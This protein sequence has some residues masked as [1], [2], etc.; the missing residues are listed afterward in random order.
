MSY[1][2]LFY[3]HFSV[4]TTN[5]PKSLATRE[6]LEASQYCHVDLKI[7]NHKVNS[8][9][10]DMPTT[11]AELRDGAQNRAQ[12]LRSIE[13]ADYYVGM[14]GGV[15]KDQHSDIY[16]LTGVV[17]IESFAGEGHFGYSCHLEVPRSVVDGLFDGRNRDMEEVM[18][19][20]SGIENIGDHQ[21]SFHA[22]TD[23]VLSRK[24]QFVLATQ[25]AIAPF[26]NEFYK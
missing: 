8:D 5:T 18:Q 19:E 15:Y 20:I 12:T 2:M 24:T 4:G 14:E 16:W 9:V 11:L 10:P 7:T 1:F 13:K 22:W 6:V 25:C 17:Y 23:G 3:M 26:F 21:G